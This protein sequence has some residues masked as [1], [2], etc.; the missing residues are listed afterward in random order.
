MLYF[1]LIYHLQNKKNAQ[2]VRG[3]GW[4]PVLLSLKY[5]NER[6]GRGRKPEALRYVFY[7]NLV[8]TKIKKN[9]LY[10]T[11]ILNYTVNGIDFGKYRFFD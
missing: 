3:A 9:T 2:I 7:I 5:R 4:K 6:I 8:F 10:F 11:L 1:T